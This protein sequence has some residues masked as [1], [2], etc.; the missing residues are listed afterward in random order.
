MAYVV[1]ALTLL[2][3]LC[4]LNLLLTLALLGRVADY[5]RRSPSTTSTHVSLLPPGTPT[6]SFDVTSEDGRPVSQEDLKGAP[7]LVAFLS[8]SCAPCHEQIPSLLS[9]I[10]EKA[11]SRAH[12]LGVLQG[13]RTAAADML[14]ALAP[15]ATIVFDGDH[16][17]LANTFEAWTVPAFY[18]LD[19]DA[20]VTY[21][22]LRLPV[23]LTNQHA[24]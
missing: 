20:R 15:V 5:A 12:V 1:A 11:L 24:A 14:K 10:Q 3:V 23:K 17:A 19:V 4:L 16:N 22:G 13:D 9:Y 21:S 2:G 18:A 7:S 6:P 8:P